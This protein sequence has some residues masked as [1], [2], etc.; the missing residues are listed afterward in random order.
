MGVDSYALARTSNLNEELGQIKY[1]FSDK[2][3]TLT[4]NVMEYKKCTVGGISYSLD[5]DEMDPQPQNILENL[6]MVF[7]FFL[8]L[9]YNYQ[10]YNFYSLCV[11]NQ[12]HT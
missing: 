10:I 4:M 2:T 7:I 3:G 12:L 11:H 5:S 6:K 1:V 9:L 8:C